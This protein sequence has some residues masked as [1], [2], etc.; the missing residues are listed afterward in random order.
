MA[1]VKVDPNA[2]VDVVIPTAINV[3]LMANENIVDNLRKA[4][5]SDLTLPSIYKRAY[6]VVNETDEIA[7]VRQGVAE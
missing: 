7:V 3:V 2:Q 1:L 6:L 4:Q 5:A